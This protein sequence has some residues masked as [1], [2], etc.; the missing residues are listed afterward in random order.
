MSKK[1]EVLNSFDTYWQPS[2]GFGDA[3]ICNKTIFLNKDYTH[4]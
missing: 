3:K 1:L 2:L 4:S